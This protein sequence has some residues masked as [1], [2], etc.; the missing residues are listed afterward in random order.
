MKRALA[1]ALALLAAIA[2]CAAPSPSFDR[3]A[4]E[5]GLVREDVVG[6]GFTH[7]IYRSHRTPTADHLDV[8]LEGDGTPWTDGRHAAVDPTPRSPLA[9][10]LMARDP[11]AAL[12]LGRPC[13][14]GHYAD[15]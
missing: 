1:L 9:L 14:H 5:L 7:A 15:P 13:Y 8:Y 6:A 2:A 12:L 3:D 4:R 10:E 11:Q